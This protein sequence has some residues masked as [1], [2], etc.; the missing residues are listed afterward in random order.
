[1]ETTT[2][3]RPAERSNNGALASVEKKA[4]IWLARRMPAWVNSDHLTALGFVSLLGAGLSYA[5]AGLILASMFLI[6][7]WFGDSLDGTLARVRDRQRPRYGFYVDHI[8]DA[9][10]S[11]FLF[12][13]LALSG[14]MSEPIA[15]G[16]L[17]AYLLL[18]IE[19]YLATY[20]MG[21]FHMSFAAFGPTELR[22]LLIAG[23]L[24]LLNKPVVAFGARHYLL[25]DVGG[26][27]GIAGMCGALVWSIARH[28]AHLYRAETRS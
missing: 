25:F 17:V 9:C 2:D 21:K 8:L 15:A 5:R 20:T 6:L 7:N 14:Y 3:F 4:L 12:A 1:M 10:G 23:N 27:I 16:L 13:G 28:T 18:S 26:A 19:V 22:L 24:A 11:L